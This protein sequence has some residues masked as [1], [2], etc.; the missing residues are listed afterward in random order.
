MSRYLVDRIVEHPHIS[1][2]ANT[3]VTE[4]GGGDALERVVL[5]GS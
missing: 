5:A 4:L 3:T 2:K 1:V